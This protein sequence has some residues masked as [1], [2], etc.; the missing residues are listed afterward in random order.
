M[1]SIVGGCRQVAKT[2]SY[3]QYFNILIRKAPFSA[4]RKL[5][6]SPNPPA[7]IEIA[8]LDQRANIPD[9]RKYHAQFFEAIRPR[10]I[11]LIISIAFS[12]AGALCLALLAGVVLRS[13]V[14][15]GYVLLALLGLLF[16]WVL[17]VVGAEIQAR[18]GPSGLHWNWLGKLF[19]IFLLLAAALLVPRA[20][21]R[22]AGLTLRMRE[23]SVGPCLVAAVLLFALSWSAETW[24]ADGTDLSPE[25]LLFQALMPGLDEEIFFRG[26]F[27]ALLARAFD[28][29][30]NDH[31]PAE[32]RSR[33]QLPSVNHAVPF[34]AWDRQSGTQPVASSGSQIFD[35]RQ[36]AEDEPCKNEDPDD[37]HSHHHAG[38]H[39]TRAVH[40]GVSPCSFLADRRRNS[41]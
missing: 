10:M 23:G 19:T 26:Y 14:R 31:A 32:R 22:E 34:V 24:A 9:R 12:M 5:S 25:R 20:G 8:M 1:A 17:V 16:Y 40:H 37:A 15:W 38:R 11:D 39:V 36:Q 35:E 28:D 13:Q 7:G 6:A 33:D 21:R 30:G 4:G 2:A 29:A 18:F 3:G 27:L 41:R